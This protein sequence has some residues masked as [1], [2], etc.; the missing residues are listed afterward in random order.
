MQQ[1]R[2][3]LGEPSL[4]DDGVVRRQKHLGDGCC[5]AV[6]EHIRNRHE[7]GRFGEH[8]RCHR[9]SAHDAHHAVAG[10]PGGDRIAHGL[11]DASKLEPRHVGG[12]TWWRRVEAAALKA[13]GA[14]QAC[15]GD[16][17]QNLSGPGVRNLDLAQLEGLGTAGFADSN[18][19]GCWHGPHRN[20]RR[21]TV[22]RA[23][24]ARFDTCTRTL[25]CFF[26]D[27]QRATRTG[28][29]VGGGNTVN[30]DNIQ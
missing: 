27:G 16:L 23:R 5:V 12:N 1:H 15:G 29:H 20:A 28:Q 19:F 9:A 2:L 6:R 24:R 8:A 13:I 26:T 21:P 17:D 22:Q 25:G 18:C 30:L 3:A 14:I 10:L 11:D 4:Q 7:L